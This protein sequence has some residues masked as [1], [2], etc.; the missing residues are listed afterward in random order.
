M[1]MNAVVMDEVRFPRAAADERIS[2]EKGVK[3]DA[4]FDQ[5]DALSL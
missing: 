3:E 1:R 4:Q 2:A 5:E